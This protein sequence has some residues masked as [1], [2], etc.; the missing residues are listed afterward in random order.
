MKTPTSREAGRVVAIGLTVTRLLLLALA[1]WLWNHRREI[2]DGIARAVFRTYS[3]GRW[4]LTQLEAARA[5]LEA[6]R[7]LLEATS[8]RAAALVDS[9]PVPALAPINSNLQTLRELLEL[10][11]SRLYRELAA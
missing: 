11:V 9:Q 4:T 6:A 2:L 7:A 5:Q 1:Q 10:W 3:A 8:A